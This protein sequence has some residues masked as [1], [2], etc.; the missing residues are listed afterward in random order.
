MPVIKVTNSIQAKLG[1]LRKRFSLSTQLDTRNEVIESLISIFEQLEEIRN[2]HNL[3]TIEEVF[4]RYDIMQ[5]EEEL[6][7]IEA[8][9][10]NQKLNELLDKEITILGFIETLIAKVNSLE[11]QLKASQSLKDTN[12]KLDALQIN[13]RTVNEKLS[14][15][16]KAPASQPESPFDP[17]LFEVFKRFSNSL[18][19]GDMNKMLARLLCGY[20]EDYFKVKYKALCDKYIGAE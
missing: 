9:L 17:E 4:R 6:N 13:L 15:L 18:F 16:M 12:Q 8:E 1:E 3:T 19:K 7:E 20:N 2:K 10:K 11:N 5:K 14:E